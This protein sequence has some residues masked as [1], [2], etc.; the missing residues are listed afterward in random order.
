MKREAAFQD[1]INAFPGFPVVLVTTRDNI[2]TVALVHRF[3]YSPFMLGIGISH[4][5]YSYQLIQAE[6]EF[7]INIPTPDQ[8]EQ[9]RLC[10]ELSGRDAD[11]FEACG[12]T[13]V[14]GKIVASSMIEE[15]P[16]SIECKVVQQLELKER[17]WFIG[18]V[19]TV[20]AEDNYDPSRSLL[21]DRRSYLLI[22]ERIGK[23]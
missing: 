23:R 11:K 18:E 21:C 17:T 5:R 10:G 19:V 14:Q 7:V 15:C 13:K 8:L 6:K 16:V 3:S 2:I 12:F 1:G 20:H 4:R 9:V 22:G